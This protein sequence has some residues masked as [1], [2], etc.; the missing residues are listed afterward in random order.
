MVRGASEA[1]LFLAAEAP[2]LAS[3]ENELARRRE[4]GAKAKEAVASVAEYSG[5]PRKEVYK[6]WLQTAQR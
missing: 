5:L 3:I 2:N 1:D 4:A 6:I